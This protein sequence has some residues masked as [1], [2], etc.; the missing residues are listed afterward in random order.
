MGG[1]GGGEGHTTSRYDKIWSK[2]IK[3]QFEAKKSKNSYMCNV[4]ASVAPCKQFSVI[5]ANDHIWRKS[6]NFP[7]RMCNS[8]KTLD[9]NSAED[10]NIKVGL[11]R[12][13]L[14]ENN[15]GNS[16][17]NDDIA[18]VQPTVTFNNILIYFFYRIGSKTTML[19]HHSI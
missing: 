10:Y 1:G 13:K 3:F 12:L 5:D 4:N 15:M 16:I 14:T 19:C 2:M 9:A 8:A 17:L 6:V 7:L 11:N 18:T